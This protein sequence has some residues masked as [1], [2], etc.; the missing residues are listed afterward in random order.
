ME[1]GELSEGL[2]GEE[3]VREVELRL[4]LSDVT[5]E[6]EEIRGLW[7]ESE[8]GVLRTVRQGV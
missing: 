6:E 3:W 2:G 8:L 4:G 5:L 7:D 1:G